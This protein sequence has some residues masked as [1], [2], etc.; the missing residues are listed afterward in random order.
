MP[1][2]SGT[3]QIPAR[4][5]F[6]GGLFPTGSS[7]KSTWPAVGRIRPLMTLSKVDLP[8]PLGPRRA[9]TLPAGM[10]RSTPWS[11]SMRP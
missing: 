2:P 7:P 11:T 5:N 10:A 4:A 8:A 9:N 1:R 6:S 3:A